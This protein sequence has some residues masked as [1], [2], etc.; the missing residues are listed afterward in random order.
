MAHTPVNKHAERSLKR[1][2]ELEVLAKA[3][4]E[5]A[6]KR[7]QI[8][9]DNRRKLEETREAASR[10]DPDARALL[11]K[12]KDADKKYYARN[13]K[14]SRGNQAR[15]LAKPQKARDESETE[16]DCE[17]GYDRGLHRAGMQESGT[18]EPSKRSAALDEAWPAKVPRRK[19]MAA[20]F[21]KLIQDDSDDEESSVLGSAAKPER[22]STVDHSSKQARLQHGAPLAAPAIRGSGHYRAGLSGVGVVT[23]DGDMASLAGTPVGGTDYSML[24]EELELQLRGIELER[25]KVNIELKL[26]ELKKSRSSA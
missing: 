24:E 21:G 25:E 6:A 14:P 11:Q 2:R 18:P 23:R 3:G 1:K 12:K 10:G 22:K 4:D 20:R 16:L 8:N 9:E 15:T 26:L 19:S 17:M 5:W 13:Y 7:L